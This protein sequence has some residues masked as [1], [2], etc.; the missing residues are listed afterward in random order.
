[1]IHFIGRAEGPG[2]TQA[3]IAKYIFPGGYIP[4]LSETMSA[5][6]SAGLIATDVEVLRL[7][8]AETLRHWRQAFEENRAEIAD[9]YGERFCHVGILPVHQRER[10]PALRPQRFP[11]P[12]R[13][14]DR[15]R[16]DHARLHRRGGE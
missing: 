11:N 12:A 4:A 3:W 2:F 16:A 14:T 7:H 15:R 1:M 10:L 8:Y 13:Q 5:I 9:L 6:E